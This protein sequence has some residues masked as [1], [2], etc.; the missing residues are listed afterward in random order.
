MAAKQ[1]LELP[2]IDKKMCPTLGLSK[3]AI[4]AW[5]AHEMLVD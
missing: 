1:K 3:G 5:A 4:P 2:R